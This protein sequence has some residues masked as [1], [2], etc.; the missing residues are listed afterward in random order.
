MSI[1]DIILLAVALAM[2]CFA[3]SIVCGVIVRRPISGAILRLCLLFGLFQAAMPL[4]GWL[5]INHFSGVLESVDHWIAFAVL[6][7]LGGKM[8]K[9]SFSD[10]E[11]I[12]FNPLRIKKQILLAIATSIDAL[13]VGI[14]F[15]C[16]GYT[17]ASSLILPLSIIGITSFLL[18][19]IGYSLGVKC[20]TAIERRL[21]P[22]LIGGIIL[23]FIGVKILLSHLFEQ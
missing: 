7:F 5:C 8:I 3:V 11:E 12:H 1:F 2:D 17:T 6:L 14:S 22:E 19:I 18:P 16:V 13:A 21:K 15:A 4:I 23:I 10:S 9:E 20:G